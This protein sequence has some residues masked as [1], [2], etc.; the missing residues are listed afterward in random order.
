VADGAA[1]AALFS[2]LGIH[3]SAAGAPGM[4][5]EPSEAALDER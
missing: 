1:A 4:N 3:V 5:V 2:V